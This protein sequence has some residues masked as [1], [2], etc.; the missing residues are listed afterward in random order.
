MLLIV[1]HM[2]GQ[3]LTGIKTIPGDYA[4]LAYA[5]SQL[6]TLGTTAPGVT[7]NIASG[8]TETVGANLT[9]T[10]ITSSASAP[11]VFQKVPSGITNPK[12]FTNNGGW[13]SATDACNDCRFYSNNISNVSNGI[14]LNGYSAPAPYTLYDQGN[15]IGVSGANNI[16][17]YEGAFICT[18]IGATNQN[19]LIISNNTITRSVNATVSNSFYGLNFTGGLQSS[20]TISSNTISIN[21]A[22]INSAQAVYGIRTQFGGT[23]TGN[24]ITISNNII[25]NCSNPYNS[26]ASFYCILNSLTT[27]RPGTIN[28]NNNVIHDIIMACSETFPIAEHPHGI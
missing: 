3:P 16:T 7:F 2:Q 17:N 21:L 6:N 4:T 20:G 15:E 24:T 12:L 8:Y 9:L 11:I 23:G 27:N 18:G 28:V 10:T 26:S 14:F 19:A 1:N 22:A 13:N 25:Q 5:I